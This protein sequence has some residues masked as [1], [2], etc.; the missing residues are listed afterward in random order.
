[1]HQLQKGSSV[2]KTHIYQGWSP[3]QGTTEGYVS[4]ISFTK[5]QSFWL[6]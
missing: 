1:V 6:H 5:F 4:P 3:K 2:H